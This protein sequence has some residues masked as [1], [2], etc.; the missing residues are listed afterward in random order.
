[1]MMMMLLPQRL[2][3]RWLPFSDIHP[4]S[5]VTKKGG[6]F[7]YESSL[8]VR[9]RASIG[10]DYLGEECALRD[11][12]RFCFIFSHFTYYGLVTFLL[13]HCSASFYINMMYVSSPLS[14][15]CCFFSLFI[16]MFLHLYKLSIF[17]TWCLDES[18]LSVSD[19]TSCKT[20]MPWSLF[21][22]SFWRAHCIS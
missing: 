1:M 22:Q 7:V 6:S 9:G 10:I 16:H 18:C 14:H 3:M 17:H 19:K 11:V 12:V 8:F 13:I 21:L 15:M 20:I 4:L 5:F 2:M